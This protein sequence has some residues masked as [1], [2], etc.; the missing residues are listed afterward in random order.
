LIGADEKR[1]AEE[2]LVA[3]LLE[4]LS[5]AETQLTPADRIAIRREALGKA[6]ARKNA[7]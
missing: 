6:E 2:Q 3:T 5:S 7:R 1:K 4:G